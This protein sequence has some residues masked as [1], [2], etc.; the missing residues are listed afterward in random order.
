MLC[1]KDCYYGETLLKVIAILKRNVISIRRLSVQLE[2]LV[3]ERNELK[4]PCI[5]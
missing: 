3:S 4:D 1:K 5:H 2:V